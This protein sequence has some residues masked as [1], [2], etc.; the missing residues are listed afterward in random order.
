MNQN[1][2]PTDPTSEQDRRRSLQL[3]LQLTSSVLILAGA[4]LAYLQLSVLL[5]GGLTLSG[6]VALLLTPRA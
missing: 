3:G 4:V 6:L 5:A 2:L 1:S